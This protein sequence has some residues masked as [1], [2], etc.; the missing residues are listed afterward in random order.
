MKRAMKRVV[1]KPVT[2]V[3]LSQG[4]DSGGDGIQLPRLPRQAPRARRARQGARRLRRAGAFPPPTCEKDACS[5]NMNYLN[6][7][8]KDTQQDDGP[9]PPRM[10][11]WTPSEMLFEGTGLGRG[12][13]CGGAG[14]AVISRREPRGPRAARD[15]ARERNAR[16]RAAALQGCRARAPPRPRRCL[17]PVGF[18]WPV[19][20]NVHPLSLSL[21]Q[22]ATPEMLRKH[23][24]F[25]LDLDRYSAGPEAGPTVPPGSLR[26]SDSF[27]SFFF[28]QS[29]VRVH[30]SFPLGPKPPPLLMLARYLTRAARGRQR[31]WLRCS[32]SSASAR[33]CGSARR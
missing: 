20:V 23:F 17:F 19:P 16:C 21:S 26:R 2:S 6:D 3:S 18:L 29:F 33:V 32:T 27:C 13:D 15:G 9:R 12:G 10:R 14:D 7:S 28:P 24:P 25:M 4:V 22:G 8:S 1:M 31:S 11:V 30:D 5:Y